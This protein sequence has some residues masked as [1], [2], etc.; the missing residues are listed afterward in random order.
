MHQLQDDILPAKFG[1]NRPP[2]SNKTILK[3]Y[4]ALLIETGSVQTSTR[5][6][7]AFRERKRLR[8][9]IEKYYGRHVEVRKQCDGGLSWAKF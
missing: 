4:T 5:N 8:K 9:V 6:H 3:W 1:K 7:A 2:P